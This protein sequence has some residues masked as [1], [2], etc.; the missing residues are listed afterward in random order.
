[1]RSCHDTDPGQRQ[2]N[3]D[4]P[5]V[6]RRLSCCRS[7]PTKRG[8]QYAGGSAR[9][10]DGEKALRFRVCHVD[11]LWRSWS[12]A[13]PPNGLELS[14][15]AEAGN[16]TRTLGQA[17]WP[18]KHPRRPC[19]PGQLQR[20]VRQ[21]RRRIEAAELR[22]EQRQQPRRLQPVLRPSRLWRSASGRTCAG[23]SSR[24]RAPDLG[25]ADCISLWGELLEHLRSV[26]LV[27]RGEGA[28]E[29]A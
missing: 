22:Q 6:C 11:S 8:G 12:I 26:I 13:L 15:P 14:C 21:R 28:E 16:A 17:G 9:R 2:R 7:T 5:V 25:V 3:P 1:M 23:Q 4:R 27:G 24:W 20:V 10:W 19:P 29:E 18:D